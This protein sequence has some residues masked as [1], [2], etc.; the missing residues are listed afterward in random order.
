MV[1]WVHDDEFNVIQWDARLIKTNVSEG[2]VSWPWLIWLIICF[3]PISV[4]L[5]LWFRSCRNSRS[6]WD[7]PVVRHCVDGYFNST[8]TCTVR[9]IFNF[10]E[11][12]LSDEHF[13]FFAGK[14][15]VSNLIQRNLRSL[16][17]N[18]IYLEIMRLTEICPIRYISINWRRKDIILITAITK[19]S[20][21]QWSSGCS[22]ILRHHRHRWKII[23]VVYVKRMYC[24]I[25]IIFWN[26]TI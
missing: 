20:W 14:Y 21:F 22:V 3:C 16:P 13:F 7:R 18:S 12:D 5:T 6:E 23:V 4:C 19:F 1:L 2:C 24:N 25:K 17:V 26:G 10:F 8:W 9:D 15:F 11:R